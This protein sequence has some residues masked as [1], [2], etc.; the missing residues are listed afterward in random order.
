MGILRNCQ[1]LL[2]L[3]LVSL[4]AASPS[5]AQQ[6]IDPKS[7]GK[8]TW[9]ESPREIQIID[10]RPLIKDFREA[11]SASQSIEL[12]SAPGSGNYGGNGGGAL[13]GGA[14]LLPANGIQ[15]GGGGPSFRSAQVGLPKSGFGGPSNI[16]ARGLGPAGALPGVTRSN[17]GNMMAKQRMAAPSSGMATGSAPPRG[18]S[19][20]NSSGNSSGPSVASYG[21]YGTG[22]GTGSG[23]ASSSQANVRG[24][25]LNRPSN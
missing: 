4:A 20:G 13:G 10:E 8:A 18:R 25:L 3:S 6:K 11:P 12:P 23:G 9:H 5:Y 1:Y 24:K 15:L 21:G 7:L 2:M 22:S 16:P 14:P 17:L 19:S